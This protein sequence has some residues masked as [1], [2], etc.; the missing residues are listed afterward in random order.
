MIFQRLPRPKNPG[1]HRSHRALHDLS[2]LF[3]S[4]SIKFPQHQ[5]NFELLRRFSFR[6]SM[7]QAIDPLSCSLEA[8]QY[9]LSQPILSGIALAYPQVGI[10]WATDFATR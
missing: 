3:I 1:P 6:R 10:R 4:Q 7:L 2:D 9:F 5:G 8:P